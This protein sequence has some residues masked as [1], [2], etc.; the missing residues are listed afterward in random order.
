MKENQ[1][2]VNAII[3]VEIANA[4]ENSRT[5]IPLLRAFLENW[6]RW[7]EGEK[8]KKRD[9]VD[10]PRIRRKASWILAPLTKREWR[11]GLVTESST[12]VLCNRRKDSLVTTIFAPTI[13]AAPGI[14]AD[15]S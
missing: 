13:K 6:N 10:L 12:I 7:E 9:E 8:W 15:I 2:P 1:R 4:D 14:V 3:A 11:P 5:V